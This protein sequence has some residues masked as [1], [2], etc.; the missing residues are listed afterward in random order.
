VIGHVAR[1]RGE[2]N[3]MELYATGAPAA[4]LPLDDAWGRR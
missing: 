1:A 2:G 4:G 3:T